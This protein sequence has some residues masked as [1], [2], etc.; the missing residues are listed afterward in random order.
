MSLLNLHAIISYASF[1]VRAK[2]IYS[3]HSPFLF[4]IIDETLE[5][6]RPYYSFFELEN[7]REILTTDQRTL[8]I[9][10]LGAGSKKNN[11]AKKTIA[12]IATTAVSPKHKCQLLFNLV[13]YLKPKGI[14]ELG[15]SLGLSALY[16]HRGH[17]KSRLTTVEGDP[18]IAEMAQRIFLDAQADIQLHIMPFEQYFKNHFSTN[19][20][21]D[22]I[23][24]D[25]NHTR[26]ATRS[27][28]EKISKHC[29]EKTIII[30]DDIYW[31]KDMTAAWQELKNDDQFSAC[32]D[33]YHYGLLIK[34]PEIKE[35]I[36]ATIIKKSYKPW[37]LGLFNS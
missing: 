24:I 30:L 33:F 17:R 6:K 25:G 36:N 8:Q 12:D 1:Y 10:D 37:K 34:N 9:T 5:N 15:T 23:Y 16:M 20:V 28:L 14:L 11:Q 26:N 27:Y 7:L 21:F 19:E 13:R 4:R 3:V 31:S 2:T 35:K 29:S 32:L 18:A 22:F